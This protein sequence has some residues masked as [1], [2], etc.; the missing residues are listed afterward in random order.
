MTV[1]NIIYKQDS[2]APVAEGL[3][4]LSLNTLHRSLS[5]CCGFEP[6]SGQMWDKP[7]PAWGWSGNLS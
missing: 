5:H 6:S 1:L 4:L 7:S 2:A 3:R